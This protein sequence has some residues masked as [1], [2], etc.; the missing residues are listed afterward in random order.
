MAEN[1]EAAS[2]DIVEWFPF[3]CREVFKYLNMKDLLEAS[4]VSK[5]W[6]KFTGQSQLMKK[7]K[8][9]FH[10][11]EPLMQILDNEV[12]LTEEVIGTLKNSPRCYQHIELRNFESE[13]FEKL[14]SFVLQR[15]R[16]WKSMVLSCYGR[17]D[18]A[19]WYKILWMI[20]PSIERLSFRFKS[21]QNELNY[22]EYPVPPQ[23]TFPK[24]KYLEN[25]NDDP[26]V[27]EYFV[28]CTTLV[29]LKYPKESSP[30][31]LPRFR[32]LR[33][34]QHGCR[35]PLLSTDDDEIVNHDPIVGHDPVSDED[36][37]VYYDESD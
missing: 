33:Q 27:C 2:Y 37:V 15:A 12:Q 17:R 23:W 25:S 30:I 20:E 19:K 26:C 1:I 3:L 32:N 18:Q 22:N 36:S 16:S 34:K 13:Q 35:F 21:S 10:D 4:L 6:Y 28:R 8:L 29:K 5:E 14:L 7:V 24:L 9:V 11:E 31:M